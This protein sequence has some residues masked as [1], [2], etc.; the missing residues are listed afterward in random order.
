LKVL[1]IKNIKFDEKTIKIETDKEDTF[2]KKDK[3][4]ILRF[5]N[6]FEL[7]ESKKLKILHK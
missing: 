5:E 4:V 2:M 3:F 1:Q 6:D 7:C